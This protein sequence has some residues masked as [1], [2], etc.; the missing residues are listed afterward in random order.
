MKA[1]STSYWR[2]WDVAVHRPVQWWEAPLGHRS[3]REEVGQEHREKGDRSR[4]V[5]GRA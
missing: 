2:D 5:M 4:R 3:P 1:M